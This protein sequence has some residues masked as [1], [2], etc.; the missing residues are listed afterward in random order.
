MPP[1]LT[2]SRDKNFLEEVRQCGEVREWSHL[3]W[4][5]MGVHSTPP[6]PPSHADR[7]RKEGTH[8]SRL[9]PPPPPLGGESPFSKANLWKRLRPL[10]IPAGFTGGGAHLGGGEG[11]LISKDLLEERRVDVHPWGKGMA[12]ASEKKK[13]RKIVKQIYFSN[14]LS[15]GYCSPFTCQS[16][17]N[18]GFTLT[19]LDK[20]SPKMFI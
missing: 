5:Y 4:P 17:A 19:G 18:T 9:D 20:F 2:T 6:Q 8:T 10:G 3:V 7:F 14:T 15:R 11:P 13:T 12:G 1:S 16:F